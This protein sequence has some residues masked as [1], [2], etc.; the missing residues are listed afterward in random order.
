MKLG[1]TGL[2]FEAVF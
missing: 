1:M 2:I